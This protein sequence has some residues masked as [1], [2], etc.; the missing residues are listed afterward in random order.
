[1]AA[2]TVVGCSAASN[3]IPEARVGGMTLAP[4]ATNSSYEIIG[5]AEG[6]ASG[7][8]LFGFIPVGVERKSGSIAG[9][10][11]YMTPVERAAVYNAIDSVPDADALI[12]PRFAAVSKNYL[13]YSEETVTVKGK[14]IRYVG[15]MKFSE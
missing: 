15:S 2:A 9:S 7:S 12:A 4:L 8:Y 3:S 13:I 6:T 10:W 5:Q 1:M 11:A 14:A